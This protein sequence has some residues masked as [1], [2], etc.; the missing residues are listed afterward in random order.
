MK[1]LDRRHEAQAEIARD[2]QLL[3]RMQSLLDE[4]DAR[5]EDYADEVGD[6]EADDE[7]K[8]LFAMPVVEEKVV[9]AAGTQEPAQVQVDEP[10]KAPVEGVDRLTATTTIP[11][12]TTT[13]STPAPAPTQPPSTLRN[14]HPAQQPPNQSHATTAK[15]TS[16]KPSPQ[17]TKL[18]E[19]EHSLS[20]QRTEQE[21]LTGSL[22][23]LAGQLKASSQSFQ[24]TLDNEKSMLD[25]AVTGI[26]KTSSTME[27]AGKRMGMLRK[28]SEGKGWWGRMML[29]AWIFGLWIV[30][31]LIVFVGPKMRF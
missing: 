19:T 13:T 15:T 24:A 25:R 12:A 5:A 29:Y 16:S 3:K 6:E 4:A 7:W 27:A 28:M 20:A 14:R 31:I 30:A 1:Q 22:L 18:Q 21:D 17:T 23:S 10:L 2:R 8:E 26:D 9:S 11:A